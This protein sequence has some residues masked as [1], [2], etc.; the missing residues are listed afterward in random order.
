MVV[1]IGVIGGVMLNIGRIAQAIKFFK[2]RKA[3]DLGLPSH[4]IYVSGIPLLTI[5]SIHIKGLSL[6]VLNAPGLL[7]L[8]VIIAGILLY[9]SFSIK[10]RCRKI[11]R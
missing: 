10:V 1:L 3:R 8:L 5:Y 11:S 6:I 9:G 2:T 7:G 4:L